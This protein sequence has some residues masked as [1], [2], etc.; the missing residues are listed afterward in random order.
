MG[1]LHRLGTREVGLVCPQAANP[2]ASA[3][4]AKLLLTDRYLRMDPE[5]EAWGLDDIEHLTNLKALATRD[6][7]LR[8]DEIAKN[9]K[10]SE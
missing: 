2:D 9:L 5:I 4:M 8:S 3:N 6:F 1:P 10:G 7:A